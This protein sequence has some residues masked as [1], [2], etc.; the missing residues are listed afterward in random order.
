MTSLT[1]LIA[2][3]HQLFRDGL[4]ALIRSTIAG[5]EIV[6][7]AENGREAVRLVRKLRPD[8]VLM[9][10]SMPELNGIEAVKQITSEQIDCK[11]IALSMH[12]STD[13]VTQMLGAG[14]KG[15][16]N[17]NA[18]VN[19]LSQA[20]RLVCKGD[21]YLG[22]QIAEKF[23]ESYPQYRAANASGPDVSLSKREREV[24]Q[25]V[26]EGNRTKTIAEKLSVSV[27][28]VETHRSQIVRKL[29][30]N[31]VVEMTKYAIRNGIAAL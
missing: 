8:V 14:A 28:T 23:T 13:F 24:L 29:H 30:L 7:E 22:K 11:V 26:A 1:L 12:Q 2:D 18:A 17:K 20:L 4:K 25:L 15:Y 16:L 31:G 3:D 6:A 21:V 10:I 5:V 19:E 9:D 27:K